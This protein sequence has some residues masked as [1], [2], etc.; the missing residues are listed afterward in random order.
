M[1]NVVLKLKDKSCKDAMKAYK[2]QK[3]D[4]KKRK[5]F[6]FMPAKCTQ[7]YS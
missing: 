2:K 1:E 7:N 6:P 4:V 5:N 3:Q